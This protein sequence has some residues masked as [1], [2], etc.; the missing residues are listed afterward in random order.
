MKRKNLFAQIALPC[1]AALLLAACG[2]KAPVV[3]VGRQWNA[4]KG[5]VADTASEFGLNDAMV[6]Q[7][8]NQT[9]FKT[10]AVEV[11]VFRGAQNSKSPVWKHEIGVK[12]TMNKATLKGTEA[13]P[14]TARNIMGSVHGPYRIAF[15]AQDSLIAFKDVRL[16]PPRST[17][18]GKP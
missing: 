6:V 3:E 11:R 16:V 15:F 17:P 10:S 18:A 2:D 7:L 1:L 14:M 13:Q 9:G 12:G 8:M 4:V 5:V